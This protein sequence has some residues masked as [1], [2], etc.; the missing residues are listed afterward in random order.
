MSEPQ[1]RPIV[2]LGA[3][4]TGLAMAESVERLPAGRFTGFLDDDPAKQSDGYEGFS[5]LGGLDDWPSLPGECLFLSSLY[6]PN[7]NRVFFDR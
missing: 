3:G 1:A 5:V 2:I 4:G 6:G 7:T